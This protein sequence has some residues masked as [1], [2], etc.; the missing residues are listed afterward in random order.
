MKT[1]T[2]KSILGLALC[3]A[4]MLS[5]C[6]SSDTTKVENNNPNTEDMMEEVVAKN[7]EYKIDIINL[8]H[9]QPLSPIAV[10]LHADGKL[11]NIGEPASNALE[12]LAESGDNSA[13]LAS[14]DNGVSTEGVLMPGNKAS[15]NVAIKDNDSALLSIASMLVN[16]NDAFVGLNAMSLSTLSVGESVKLFA[17][18]YD[19]GTEGNSESTGTI[20]GPADG[21]QG[22]D[23]ARDDVNFVAMHPGVVSSD[24]G[25]STSV[26]TQDHKFDNPSVQ[27]IVSRIE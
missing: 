27:F 4:L 17:Y 14:L 26:L 15:I 16:T 8:T 11:W 10:A 19:S 12:V 21:G 24:D 6:G 9:S 18:T 7:Y 13:L 20:P 25:L 5:A 22:Y 3:S 2:N 1:Q 23:E